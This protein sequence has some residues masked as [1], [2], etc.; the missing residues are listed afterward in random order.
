MRKIFLFTLCLL[1][2]S[3]AK[4]TIS[5]VRNS[6]ISIDDLKDMQY[7]ISNTSVKYNDQNDRRF[8]VEEDDLIRSL[9]TGLRKN[10][11]KNQL[12]D[13]DGE[14]MNLSIKII[15]EDKHEVIPGC[16]K[17]DNT[18]FGY[19]YLPRKYRILGLGGLNFGSSMTTACYADNTYYNLIITGT[20][21]NNDNNDVLFETKLNYKDKIA[22]TKQRTKELKNMINKATEYIGANIADRISR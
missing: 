19:Y 2:T 6:N 17:T 16:S 9:R 12:P 22:D 11:Y 8:A 5:G 1:L 15:T 20:R 4:Y 3:C 18:G 13:G 21:Q 7:K 10:F 14:T